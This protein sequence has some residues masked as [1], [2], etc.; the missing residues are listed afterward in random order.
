VGLGKTIE[1][2]LVSILIQENVHRIDDLSWP[3]LLA[4]T[5]GGVGTGK[6]PGT[7]I[8]YSPGPSDLPRRPYPPSSPRAP[9]GGLP[10]AG[11]GGL[12]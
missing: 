12:S 9:P 1:A 10:A 5:P 11:I 4:P 7:E 6:C 2:G 3:G 8:F